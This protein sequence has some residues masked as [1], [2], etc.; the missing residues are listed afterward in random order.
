M[1]SKPLNRSF[2]GRTSAD[3]VIEGIDL[4]GRTIVVTG[5]N[6]GIGYETARALAAGGARVVLACRDP[7]SGERAA[8]RIRAAHPAARADA[9]AL[10]LASLSSVRS[11]AERL[12]APAVHAVICNAGVFCGTYAETAEGFELTVGVCHIG[13]FQLVLG[14]R[15]RLRAAAPARV[16]MVSSES[17]RTPRRL[18][19]E[20]LPLRREKY[21]A[22]VAYGQAKLCN[23]LMANELTRRW[24]ADGVSASS[25]HPGTLMLTG[26]G[27][28]S[29]GAR[30][31]L[32]L[33]KPFAKT[34]V[35]GAATSVYCATA[36]ALEAGEYY[37]DCRKAV[38]S[39][40]ARD[41]SVAARL[42]E[43]S[44][45]WLRAAASAK[46]SP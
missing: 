10:D 16:V 31:L 20:R 7:A 40:E 30:V 46:N 5:A 42:W 6:S 18:L 32:T 9:Q 22:L 37:L 39:A 38:A 2:G 1:E 13:H 34:L 28:N 3:Q 14:L 8:A 25:L 41:P 11:F 26:I 44:E 24:R 27:K 4:A 17:H 15:D 43:T 29:L 19:F 12:D 21:R 23:V 35:Q 33:A 45:R 36:P